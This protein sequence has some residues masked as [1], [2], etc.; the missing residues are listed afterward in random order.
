M[1][2]KKTDVI[3]RAISCPVRVR[4]RDE[5]PTSQRSRFDNF[6][7]FRSVS[8]RAAAIRTTRALNANRQYEMSSRKTTESYFE[9]FRA[10]L[11]NRL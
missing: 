2:T 8:I 6:A 5:R 10:G 7:G 1:A 4:L 9:Y 3:T 11:G